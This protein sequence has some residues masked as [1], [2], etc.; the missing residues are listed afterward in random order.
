MEGFL[1]YLQLRASYGNEF[2]ACEWGEGLRY[3]AFK[4]L[5]GLGMVAMALRVYFQGRLADLFLALIQVALTLMFLLSAGYDRFGFLLLF[6]PAVFLAEFMAALWGKWKGRTGLRIGFSLLFI[7][8][9]AQK[10]P[11]MLSLRLFFPD[12]INQEEVWVIEHIPKGYSVFT[13]DQQIVPFL[14]PETPY[15]LPGSVP[16][17]KDNCKNLSLK[18]NEVLIAGKYANT[19]YQGCIDW[20]RLRIV[21]SVASTTGGYVIWKSN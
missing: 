10:S 12:Q 5:F 6:I 2:F 7:L 3:L 11:L 21:D 16:S 8:I 19:E 18:V 1:T 20:Q 13:Y 4:P 15:R 14:S 9:F 17:N